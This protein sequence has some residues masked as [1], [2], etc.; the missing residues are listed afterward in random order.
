MHVS[1]G[2]NDMFCIDVVITA[3]GNELIITFQETEPFFGATL[4]NTTKDNRNFHI[5]HF[6]RATRIT[7]FDKNGNIDVFFW[8]S[9]WLYNVPSDND[10][11]RY[12][13]VCI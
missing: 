4:V 13:L 2:V 12:L 1:R 7:F 6:T 8:R 11:H 9:L 3:C 10:C 5:C